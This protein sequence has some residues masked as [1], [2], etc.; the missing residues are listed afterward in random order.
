M[1]V[2][3]YPL[4]NAVSCFENLHQS[5]Y[6]TSLD[7]AL[8]YWSVPLHE[9]SKEKTAFTVQSGKYKFNAMPFGLTNE[10]ATFAL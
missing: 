6:F 5:F 4:T 7:L 3:K 1:K 2:S 8:A 10:V 9:E